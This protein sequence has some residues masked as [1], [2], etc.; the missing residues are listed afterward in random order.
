MC[1]FWKI[2]RALF[3]CNTR[4]EIRPFALLPTNLFLSAQIS[5]TP[6]LITNQMLTIQLFTTSYDQSFITNLSKLS[7]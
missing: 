2:W 6:Y 1:V 5:V 7:P 4:F 3:S